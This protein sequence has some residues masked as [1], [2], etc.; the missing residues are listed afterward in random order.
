MCFSTHDEK[1]TTCLFEN[2]TIKFYNNIL[3]VINN[4]TRIEL[5]VANNACSR[6]KI[7]FILD[8]TRT[9]ATKLI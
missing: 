7:I 2:E 5:I 4:Y 3:W 6:E 8:F 9:F 1:N